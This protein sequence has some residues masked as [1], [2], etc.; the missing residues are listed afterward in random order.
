MIM[1]LCLPVLFHKRSPSSKF[2]TYLERSF[3]L[4]VVPPSVRSSV[5]LLSAFLGICSFSFFWFLAQWC[6]MVMPKMWRSPI[7]EK[8]IFLGK[9]VGRFGYYKKEAVVVFVIVLWSLNCQFLPFHPGFFFVYLTLQKG[10]F[11][12]ENFSKRGDFQ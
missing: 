9:F 8:K 7:F 4:T 5:C 1:I 6:K 11:S 12:R 10:Q 3:N 2:W